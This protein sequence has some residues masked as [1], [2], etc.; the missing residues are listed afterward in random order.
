ML[1]AKFLG[2]VLVIKS[3]ELFFYKVVEPESSRIIDTGCLSGDYFV[4]LK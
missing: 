1:T 3:S 4:N 2:N